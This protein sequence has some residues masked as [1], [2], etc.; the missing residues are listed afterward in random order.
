MLVRQVSPSQSGACISVGKGINV[1][2][3]RTHLQK[4]VVLYMPEDFFVFYLVP[5]SDISS[6]VN[7][8][9]SSLILL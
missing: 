5:N 1:R 4:G 3:V 6:L 8:D 7:V 9:A 2:I